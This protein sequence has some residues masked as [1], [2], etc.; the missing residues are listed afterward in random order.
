M[1][2]IIKVEGYIC[3]EDNNS[4]TLA[5]LVEWGDVLEKGK[6]YFSGSQKL[7]EDKEQPQ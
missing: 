3:R 2:K 7:E 4:M 1:P 6:Y 5:D